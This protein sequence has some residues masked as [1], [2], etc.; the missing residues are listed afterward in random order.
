MR[1][2]PTKGGTRSNENGT[3]CNYSTVIHNCT[4]QTKTVAMHRERKILTEQ[5]SAHSVRHLLRFK[6]V[7]IAFDGT[8][9]WYSASGGG[10]V[11]RRARP[12]RDAFYRNFSQ[13][14]FYEPI[15]VRLEGISTSHRLLWETRPPELCDCDTSIASPG[16]FL[17]SSGTLLCL[18]SVQRKHLVGQPLRSPSRLLPDRV[19]EGTHLTVFV[20]VLHHPENLARPI[21]SHFSH[22]RSIT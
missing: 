5:R 12:L 6:F 10:A 18:Y 15:P 14:P 13:I 7:F 2:N 11:G 1:S 8:T 16:R 3:Q 4:C 9:M 20:W 17:P 22:F 21:S 19:D